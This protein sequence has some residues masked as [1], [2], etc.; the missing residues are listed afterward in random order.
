M[1]QRWLGLK[2]LQRLSRRRLGECRM[3]KKNVQAY[4]LIRLMF[5]APLNMLIRL[6]FSALVPFTTDFKLNF[7]TPR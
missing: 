6:M 2:L 5:S 3:F 1:V 7:R 4:V